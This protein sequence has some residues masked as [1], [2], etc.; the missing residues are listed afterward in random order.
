MLRRRLQLQVTMRRL[1]LGLLFL[2]LALM[3]DARAPRAPLYTYKVGVLI[4][5]SGDESY[6]GKSL[7]NGLRLAEKQTPEKDR[8]LRLVFEDSGGSRAQVILGTRKLIDLERAK[9]MITQGT[10]ETELAAPIQEEHQVL[11]F[12]YCWDPTITEKYKYIFSGTVTYKSWIDASLKLLQEQ[13]IKKIAGV[14][15]QEAGDTA[16]W[17]Y[18]KKNAGALGIEITGEALIPAEA[19]DF[20]ATIAKMAE[21]KPEMVFMILTYPGSD[22]F[23]KQLHELLPE[24]GATGYLDHVHDKSLANGMSY[25]SEQGDNIDFKKMY[26]DEYDTDDFHLIAM[27][28]YD[29]YNI[30]NQL[31]KDMPVWDAERARDR[32][33]ELKSFRGMSGTLSSNEYGAIEPPVYLKQVQFGE[34]VMIRWGAFQKR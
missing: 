6:L 28:G 34:P 1:A 9:M 18:L 2:S 24:L 31:A 4:P 7:M 19:R 26:A 32:L 3:A 17:E 25:I 29:T 8:Y 27:Y 23:L 14:I 16:A 30:L 33:I 12:N 11:S 5:L 13:R 10:F 21:S 22:I 20:R 15:A